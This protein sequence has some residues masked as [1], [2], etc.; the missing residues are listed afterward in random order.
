MTASSRRIGKS[1][2]AI[3]RKSLQVEKRPDVFNG[4]IVPSKRL[5]TAVFP[6]PFAENISGPFPEA[7]Q[8]A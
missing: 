7:E 5:C 1:F 3:Y 4:R 8:Q 6:E 2:R